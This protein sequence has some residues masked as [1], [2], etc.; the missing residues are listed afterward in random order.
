MRDFLPDDLAR[1][2][3]ALGLIREVYARHNYRPIETPTLE[4]IEVLTGK[5][6]DEGDQLMFK[7]LKRGAKLQ[8]A[9]GRD[10]VKPTD[11][12]DMG[13]RYDLTVPLSRVVAQHHARLPRI[14]KCYQLRPVWRADRPA[15]GRFREFYQCDVDI[16]GSTSPLVEVD[17]ITAAAEALVALGFD[18][19]RIRINDRQLL[20]ATATAAGIVPAHS[21]SAL[22]ALDKIDKIGLD[23]VRDELIRQGIAEAA[24]DRL[25]EL[26]N[27]G[28]HGGS[29]QSRLS[30]F[31][32]SLGE[33][34]PASSAEALGQILEL[35]SETLPDEAT[36]QY[37]PSLV[38]GLTY[39]TGAIFEIS[40][41]GFA[42]SIGGGGRYDNLIG[43]FL[44]RDIPACGISLGVERL[45]MIM[46]ERGMFP[47]SLAPCHVFMARFP[48]VS[49][50]AGLRL[51]GELRR[52]GLRVDVH[53]DA[54]K[55]KKQFGVAER[56]GA[57]VVAMIGPDEL[58]RGE[59]KLKNLATSEQRS[60]PE[61]AVLATVKG[62][63]SPAPRD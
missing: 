19:F 27:A 48:G 59:V 57:L 10:E 44:G 17:V 39:Y 32:E 42:G 13:L 11:L 23:G 60:V 3:Y 37:D 22:S 25:L 9:L 58:A 14:F 8:R 50:G 55:L 34:A 4:R 61:G 49:L 62:W 5:Y 33:Q 26:A 45:L 21:A 20:A 35:L 12:S 16:V 15:R 38:R 56:L 46:E 41:E 2:D 63:I 7:V 54:S 43:S 29:P 47:D 24:A 6:G 28:T 36:L 40:L 18:S 1:R 53:P 52:A 51:V 30:L 31:A